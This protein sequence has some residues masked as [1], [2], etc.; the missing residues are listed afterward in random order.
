MKSNRTPDRVHVVRPPENDDNASSQSRGASIEIIRTLAQ[1]GDKLK[2]S[3]AERY[4]LLAE[5][6]EYRKSLRDLEDKAD[7]SEKAY[8]TVQNKL[9]STGSLD[10]ENVQR[11]VRFE[12]SLKATEDKML[13]A[14]AGQAVIDKR[15]SDTEDKQIMIDQRLDQSVAEQAKLSR[16][17]D[18]VSQDKARMMRKVERLEE[19]VSETQ[20]SLRAKA[21]VLLTDQSQPQKSNL[22][23]PSWSNIK[24]DVKTD[25]DNEEIAL[26]GKNATASMQVEQES[27]Y[28][29]LNIQSLSTAAL[30]VA[31]LLLGWAINRSQN[32]DKAVDLGASQVVQEI[33]LS[34]FPIEKAAMT[35]DPTP[36]NVLDYNDDQLMEAFNNDSDKLASQLNN[37]EPAA[38]DNAAP[39]EVVQEVT[40]QDAAQNLG[41]DKPAISDPQITP[42]MNNFEQIAYAQDPQIEKAILAE[43]PKGGLVSR[44]EMDS[45][46]PAN[47]KSIEEQAFQGNAEAQHDL[48]AIYTAGH[49]NVEQNFDKA[50]LWFREASD[51][52][53]ANARYNLGVLY[54][55]GLGKAR[56]LSRALYWYREAAKLGHAEAQY[57]LG[58]AH[59]EGIGTEYNPQLAAEYFERAA[60]NGIM[61]AAYNLGLIHDNGLMGKT[62]ADEALLW[63]KIAADQGSKE[64]LSAMEQLAKTL[65][66]GL[67]DVDNLVDRMQLINESVKGRRAG[68]TDLKSKKTSQTSPAAAQND[69]NLVTQ[70]QQYLMLTG[71]YAGPAD[72]VNGPATQESIRAYQA[73]NNLDVNGQISKELLNSMV[74]GAIDRLNN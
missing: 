56:D 10:T 45:A 27:G 46:L 72:G 14:I 16:Q 60:N 20:D 7:N 18:I 24:A 30:V 29:Y 17:L 35:S 37:I 62:K 40:Q 6:R 15:L 11:Q 59:I 64:A 73:A 55:Q 13:K 31:A 43:K 71:A 41:Q 42:Q 66:I 19:I 69:K 57:N 54:H 9:K 34:D 53:I 22:S 2:R 51:N 50:A 44:I 23:A 36:E 21:M 1:I 58:I 4:E 48:A 25:V 39:V 68:P 65:Q 5:L 63:Y 61:E 3:E 32:S 49:A 74:G 26:I 52:G 70:I 67:G 8:L 33:E 28:K 47:V 38:V 12:N